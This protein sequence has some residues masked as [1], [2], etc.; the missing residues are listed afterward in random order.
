MGGGGG[1]TNINFF[2]TTFK[3]QDFTLH[4]AVFFLVLNSFI[5][6]FLL[7]SISFFFNKKGICSFVVWFPKY[8]RNNFVIHY[9]F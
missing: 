7:T 1:L 5:F 2:P 3:V 9:E 4:I 8:F 6:L